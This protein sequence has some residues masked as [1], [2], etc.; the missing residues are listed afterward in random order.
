MPI[1]AALV[2][3]AIGAY[4]AISGGIKARQA[5]NAAQALQPPGYT[6]N[7]AIN[8]YYQSALNRYNAGPYNSAQYQTGKNAANQAFGAGIGALQD[9]RS[10]VA[11]IGALTQGYNNSLQRVGAQAEQTQR[12]NF[13]QLGQAANM[14]SGE[15]RFDY[16]QN[17]QAP[18]Q[19]QLQL[20][21][22]QLGGANSLI[23]SGIS[24]INTGVQTG[25]LAAMRANPKKYGQQMGYYYPQ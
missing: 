15:S 24:N 13:G 12:Q 16:Q 1:V 7:K 11:N 23:S 3:A 17:Q 2:P 22:A 21:Y 20:D 8:D 18:Y 25:V 19:K 4:Q 6:P 5:R 10:G 9:R 14:Q